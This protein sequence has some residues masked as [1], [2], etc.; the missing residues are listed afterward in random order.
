MKKGISYLCAVYFENKAYAEAA[1]EYLSRVRGTHLQ[2]EKTDEPGEYVVA[3]GIG[4]EPLPHQQRMML[5]EFY[6][7]E[8][9]LFPL[10]ERKD[11]QNYSHTLYF[12]DE[13]DMERAM[14]YLIDIDEGHID[15]HAMGY[16]E[17]GEEYAFRVAF[18]TR[19]E[20]TPQQQVQIYGATRTL[21]CVWNVRLAE[22]DRDPTSIF[23]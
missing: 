7:T 22:G 19:E 15:E 16:R 23:K 20:L 2:V 6:P 8:I 13:Q 4:Y 17:G 11:W 12:N 5:S 3:F 21:A 14:G 10:N 18:C 1:R 9:S